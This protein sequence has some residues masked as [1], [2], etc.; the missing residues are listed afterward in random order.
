MSRYRSSVIP[1]ETCRRIGKIESNALLTNNEKFGFST[2]FKRAGGTKLAS[3]TAVSAFTS[4]N[5]LSILR[6]GASS[7][8]GLAACAQDSQVEPTALNTN[9]RQLVDARAGR[10]NQTH[11]RFLPRGTCPPCRC[12]RQPTAAPC[13]SGKRP[14]THGGPRLNGSNPCR[15]LSVDRHTG[16]NRQTQAGP[17]GGQLPGMPACAMSC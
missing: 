12:A 15:P 3:F 5:L 1:T 2:V 17:S 8:F 14:A 16:R 7:S 10:R 11:R 4:P 9:S 6:H 13:S